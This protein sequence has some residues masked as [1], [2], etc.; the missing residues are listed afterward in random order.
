MGRHETIG[1]NPNLIAGFV[2][3]KE[4]VIEAFGPAGFKKPIAIMA[5]PGDVEGTA[6]V[7]DGVAGEAGHRN[8]RKQREYQFQESRQEELKRVWKKKDWE[9]VRISESFF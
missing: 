1:I 7:E 6:V 5:L 3:Q 9:G 8:E 4:M 2:F